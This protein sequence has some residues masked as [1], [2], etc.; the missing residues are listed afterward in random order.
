MAEGF[1]RDLGGDRFQVASA[2]IEPGR[3]HPLAIQA[4]AEDGID[5]SLQES[6]SVERYVDD[7]FDV[8]ITVCDD[9]NEACPIFPNASRRLHW[10][11]PDPSRAKGSDDE[12][13]AV[14]ATVR[15][16]IRERIE[17]ELI[18]SETRAA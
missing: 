6:K 10:S 16:A 1:L 11:F 13:F 3:L 17:S 18:N 12:V 7:R 8:V 4:M 2:G 5:I 15:D 9:A 14:F